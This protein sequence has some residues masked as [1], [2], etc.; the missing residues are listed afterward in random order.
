MVSVELWGRKLSWS[1]LR[2]KEVK[3]MGEEMEEITNDRFSKKSCC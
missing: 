1:A 2:K 3:D